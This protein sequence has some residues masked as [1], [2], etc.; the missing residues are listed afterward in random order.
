M[1]NSVDHSFHLVSFDIPVPVNY[2]G[3]IDVFHKIKMLSEKGAGIHL[4]CFQYGRGPA[5]ILLEYCKTV[6]YYPRNINPWQLFTT[7]PYIVRSRTS[8]RLLKE[9]LKDDKPILFE[10]LHSCHLLSHPLLA[11]RKKIVRTHNIEHD[12]YESLGK[13]EK[14]ILRRWYFF[15]E[16]ARLK[17]F[18]AVLN[19]ADG[20]AAISLNDSLYFSKKYKNV[21][22]VS[23]FHPFSEMNNMEGNGKYA[24][25]H[26]SLEVGENNEAALFLVRKV[27]GETSIPLII[28]GNKPSKEL[29]ETVSK[30]A[31]IE[32]RTGLNTE[33]IYTL[34][35]QA[36][37]N[38]LPTFQATGI[39]LKLLAALY[40]GRH[41]VVNYPMV[42]DTGLEELCYIENTAEQMREQ[43]QKLMGVPFSMIDIEK[44]SKILLNNGFSNIYNA[45]ILF[46]MLFN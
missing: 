28:A 44:R 43:I 27:F 12:Y 31:N 2:G 26:G 46:D 7:L 20:V 17:K 37:I 34:V 45:D 41:C 32:L 5:E 19:N 4:H 13:V 25:Y 39:K 9:L 35:Q 15:A 16:S 33:D 36:H 18:E 3:A 21:V 29:Q 11:N 23:A 1:P 38:V 42:K 14:N 22:K 30:Y 40:T 24:L 6:D 10:G 8:E